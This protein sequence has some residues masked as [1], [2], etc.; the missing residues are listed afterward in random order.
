M[1]DAHDKLKSHAPIMFTTDLRAKMDPS[2]AKISNAS[3]RIQSSSRRRSRKPG[4]S[5]RIA[6]WG[7]FRVFLALKVAEPQLWQDPIPKVDHELIDENDIKELKAKVL[8]SRLSTS[9]LVTTAWG[10]ASTFRGSDKRGGADGE[11]NPTRPAKGLGSQP[12]RQTGKSAIGIGEDSEGLQQ[13]SSTHEEESINGRPDRAGGCQAVEEAAKKGGQ[14]VQVP[15]YP[16]R[17]DAIAEMT[18]AA[19]IAFLEPKSDGF[20]NHLAKRIDRPAEELLV[21]RA[22]LLTLDSARDDGPC[23]WHA[24]LKHQRGKRPARRAWHV[25]KTPG[26]VDERFLR[27]SARYGYRVAQVPCLRTLLR[28]TRPQNRGREV[29]RFASIWSSVRTHSFER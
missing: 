23:R 5:S 29:D 27:Q 7:P 3:T 18:D 9:E 10:S 2:Y 14:N 22:Q 26:N 16:G 13:C 28:R 11:S 8:A 21:D 24:C 4:T 17:A 6:T 25:H 15:F 19:S 20:R 12:T 1:P